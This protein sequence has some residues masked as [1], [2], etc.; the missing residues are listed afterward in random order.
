RCLPIVP[1]SD[2]WLP[3]I[4]SIDSQ[5]GNGCLCVRMRLIVQFDPKQRRASKANAG[6]SKRYNNVTYGYNELLAASRPS[7]FGDPRLATRTFRPISATFTTVAAAG[8]IELLR[9]APARWRSP[10]PQIPV[11][12]ES[13]DSSWNSSPPSSGCLRRT[14]GNAARFSQAGPSDRR[15]L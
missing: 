12:R 14:L 9:E 13:G 3:A 15:Q 7:I 1:A 8:D 4:T 10:S 2:A 5:V 6:T 11:G